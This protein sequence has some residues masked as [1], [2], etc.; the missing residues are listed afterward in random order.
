M[1]DQRQRRTQR[2][3]NRLIGLALGVRG[4]ADER[5]AALLANQRHQLGSQPRLSDAGFAGEKRHAA[6]AGA[7]RARPRGAQP[8]ELLVASDQRQFPSA[9]RDVA[10]VP[11]EDLGRFA[12]QRG[13]GT[14]RVAQ[15][16]GFRRSD[17]PQTLRAS[18]ARNARTRRSRPERFSPAS[19][20]AIIHSRTASSRHSSMS[21]KRCA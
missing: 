12:R 8:L 6:V 1:R 20:L 14:D 10:Q 11:L 5:L 18:G 15:G 21:S 7:P 13:L 16:G 3:E 19:Y 4:D 17:R 9:M 2:D